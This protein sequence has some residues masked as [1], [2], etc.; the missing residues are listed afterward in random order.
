MRIATLSWLRA[1][2]FFEVSHAGVRGRVCCTPARACGCPAPVALFRTSPSRCRAV[3]WAARVVRETGDSRQPLLARQWSAG[4]VG[5]LGWRCQPL[6]RLRRSWA[7]QAVLGRRRGSRGGAQVFAFGGTACDHAQV[8]SR[9]SSGGSSWT[10][11]PRMCCRLARSS[12]APTTRRGSPGSGSTWRP[13]T[14]ASSWRLRI[15]ASA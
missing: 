12:I 9:P 3:G 14:R 8:A 15:C 13:K 5:A 4:H 7:Q 11:R 6:Q 10:S 1:S 2:V